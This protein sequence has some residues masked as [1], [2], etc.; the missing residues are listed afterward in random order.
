MERKR[1]FTVVADAIVGLGK[2]YRAGHE[3]TEDELWGYV[4][5]FLAND[6]IRPALEADFALRDAS[7]WPNSSGAQSLAG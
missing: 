4:D 7:T 3:V 1:R 6:A 5:D 2:V